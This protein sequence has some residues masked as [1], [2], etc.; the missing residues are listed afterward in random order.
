[1]KKLHSYVSPEFVALL[2]SKSISLDYIEDFYK[3]TFNQDLKVEISESD[4][5]IKLATDIKINLVIDNPN[6]AKDNKDW[7]IEFRSK[8]YEKGRVKWVLE[9]A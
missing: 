1:M 9:T 7:S 5:D 6:K 2:D 4:A 8:N 3:K